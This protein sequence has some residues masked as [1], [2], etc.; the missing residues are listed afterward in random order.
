MHSLKKLKNGSRLLWRKAGNRLHCLF[1]ILKR[2][3]LSKKKKIMV[4]KKEKV[5]EKQKGKVKVKEK[6]KEKEKR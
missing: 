5:K 1:I 3:S 4:L 6:R 2:T